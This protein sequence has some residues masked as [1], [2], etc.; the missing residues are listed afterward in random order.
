MNR[1]TKKMRISTFGVSS[2][3]LQIFWSCAASV[4]ADISSTLWW[5][6]LKTLQRWTPKPLRGLKKM[7]QVYTTWRWTWETQLRS[8]TNPRSLV[9]QV[10]FV[11]SLLG[12]VCPP[13]FETIAELE[14]YHPRIALKWQLGRIFALF[15]GN[16]YTF[17]FALFD[18]VTAKVCCCTQTCKTDKMVSNG[19]EVIFPKLW[20]LQADFIK[21]AQKSQTGLNKAKLIN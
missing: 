2:G 13:L 8:L 11:M 3:F 10:E 6:V 9:F 4:A 18:E 17:L 14:D 19:S 7:R 5:N 20:N 16:L 12:L 21:L 1:R 15:L